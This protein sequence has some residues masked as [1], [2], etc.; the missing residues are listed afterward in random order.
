M[1][2]GR[3]GREAGANGGKTMQGRA[4]PLQAQQDVSWIHLPC[5]AAWSPEP[6]SGTAAT[7]T[8][9][10]TSSTE[11]ASW[12]LGDVGRPNKKPVSPWDGPIALF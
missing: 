1:T 6:G 10:I 11:E 12:A 5:E 3:G 9:H 7:P 4:W 2:E 8:S